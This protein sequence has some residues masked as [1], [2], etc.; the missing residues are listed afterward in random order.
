MSDE[1]GV[2]IE[3]REVI[4]YLQRLEEDNLFE[5]NLLTEEENNL[6]KME[7]E[8]KEK[9]SQRQKEIREVDQNI[10]ML[11]QSKQK[12]LERIEYY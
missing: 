4:Q 2:G 8:S 5:M 7:K 9:I 3:E 1:D 10:A 6:E 12:K 11:L